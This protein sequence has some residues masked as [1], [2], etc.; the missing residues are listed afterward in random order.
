VL[1]PG[2]ETNTE[3]TEAKA[4]FSAMVRRLAHS[5]AQLCT[6]LRSFT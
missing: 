4:D 5:F 6:A 2:L 3:I 1:E